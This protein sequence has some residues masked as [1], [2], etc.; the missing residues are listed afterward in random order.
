MPLLKVPAAQTAGNEN[1]STLEMALEEIQNATIEIC[2]FVKPPKPAP[3]HTIA[4]GSENVPKG[5]AAGGVSC[6]I[7]VI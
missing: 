2:V 6:K 5:Q 4:P 7:E 3:V 1:I